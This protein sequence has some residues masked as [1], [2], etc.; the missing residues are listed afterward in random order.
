MVSPRPAYR[1][2]H[3]VALAVAPDELD[4]IEHLFNRSILHSFQLVLD[5]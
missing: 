1:F 5:G 3:I 2:G 4:V